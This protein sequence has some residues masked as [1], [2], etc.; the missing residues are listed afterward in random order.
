MMTVGEI[1]EW[2][3]TFEDEDELGIDDDAMRLS[4]QDG[5]EWLE[6]GALRLETEE[7]G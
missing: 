1:R 5:E 2:L 3:S 4:T 7:V 6:V